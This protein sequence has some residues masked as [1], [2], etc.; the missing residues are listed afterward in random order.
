MDNTVDRATARENFV[1]MA[2]SMRHIQGDEWDRGMTL[3]WDVVVSYSETQINKLLSDKFH[4]EDS[5]MI[6]T[7][8]FEIPRREKGKKVMR[9]YKLNIG[10]PI[11]QFHGNTSKGPSCELKMVISSGT[12]SQLPDTEE[13]PIAEY[14][15]KLPDGTDSTES[16]VIPDAFVFS[17]S[18]LSLG[19]VV[20]KV[21]DTKKVTPKSQ[22]T[23]AGSE[24]ITFAD[25]E[26]DGDKQ[27]WVT[28][29]FE[30]SEDKKIRVDSLTIEVLPNGALNPEEFDVANSEAS[31]LQ[32]GMR[33][34][35]L[36]PTRID[37][38]A[39]S[40]ASVTNQVNHSKDAHADLTPKMFRM[41]TF[42]SSTHAES[43]LSLFI[44]VADGRDAGAIGDDLQAKW[45]GQWT[46]GRV[47][48]AP[49]PIGYSASIMIHPEV[50]FRTMIK[51]GMEHHEGWGQKYKTTPT[52]DGGRITWDAV[53]QFKQ[54]SGYKG[55]EYRVDRPI[56]RHYQWQFS[57]QG[58]EIDYEAAPIHMELSHPVR[59]TSE[60]RLLRDKRC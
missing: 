45:I 8:E 52:N 18:G 20:G 13:Y 14:F 47:N 28:L 50:V 33:T 46:A 40:I 39:Y 43:I 3:G 31:E 44:H 12:W 35:L 15:P 59:T 60:K 38:I 51:P 4:A 41:A 54:W 21:G 23:T 27:G 11:I 5:N 36:D 10:A 17:I 56:N 34:Y 32:N 37:L 48:S 25:H 55:F 42:R 1:R 9:R 7:I 19:T 2:E 24:T 49:I 53:Y 58:F 6:K 29:D 30:L 16:Q 26:A 22:K 57:T